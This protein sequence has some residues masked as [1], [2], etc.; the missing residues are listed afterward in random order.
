MNPVSTTQQ[1][2]TDALLRLSL[3]LLQTM[4]RWRV[5]QTFNSFA[6]SQAFEILLPLHLKLRDLVVPG[7]PEVQWWVFLFVLAQIL[8]LTL[9]QVNLQHCLLRTNDKLDTANLILGQP[10]QAASNCIQTTGKNLVSVWLNPTLAFITF[11]QRTI[12]LDDT[13]LQ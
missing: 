5:S 10:I 8:G 3:F 13:F 12:H 7:G 11:V 2:P 4:H 1:C 6:K 9:I